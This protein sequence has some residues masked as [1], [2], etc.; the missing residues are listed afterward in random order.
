LPDLDRPDSS[1]TAEG[2]GGAPPVRHRIKLPR[3]FDSFYDREFRWFYASMLG[4]MASMNMQLVIRGLLAYALTESY[5]WLGIIGLAGALPQLFFSVFGG[6]IADRA[7]KRTVMQ[8]GQGA[9]LLNATGLAAFEF[10]GWMS[11][12]A[13][14]VSA[15]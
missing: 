4:N 8:L 2:A 1:P 7:P 13:L 5:A 14:L 12:E 3:T 11:I 10:L 9:S 15:V 6:V